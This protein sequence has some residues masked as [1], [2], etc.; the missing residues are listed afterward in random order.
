MKSV[1]VYHP[2]TDRLLGRTNTAQQV[3]A[4]VDAIQASV[5]HLRRISVHA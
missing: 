5:T 2:W 3:D 1:R 4:L